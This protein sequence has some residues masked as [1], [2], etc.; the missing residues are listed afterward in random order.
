L[1]LEMADSLNVAAWVSF[2]GI[3]AV[4]YP[5]TTAC[6]LFE[7]SLGRKFDLNKKVLS[8]TEFA[9]AASSGVF[10][11]FL[12]RKPL[13]RAEKKLLL[14]NYGKKRFKD[15]FVSNPH[16]DIPSLNKELRGDNLSDKGAENMYYI[17]N[18]K[19]NLFLSKSLS[20]INIGSL[21]KNKKLMSQL[22]CIRD[23]IESAQIVSLWLTPPGETTSPCTPSTLK[24]KYHLAFPNSLVDSLA[25]GIRSRKYPAFLSQKPG[26]RRE[27]VAFQMALRDGIKDLEERTL[28]SLGKFPESTFNLDNYC[29]GNNACVSELNEVSDTSPSQPAD[30]DVDED[31]LSDVPS[32]SDGSEP[33]SFQHHASSVMESS[34]LIRSIVEASVAFGKVMSEA[35]GLV[36]QKKLDLEI[37]QRQLLD[38]D[39]VAEFYS[40]NASDGYRMNRTRKDYLQQRHIIKNEILV[41]EMM[42]NYFCNGITASGISSFVNSIMNLDRRCYTT[43]ALTV[44]EVKNLIRNPK[45]QA[46]ILG[47]TYEPSA[48]G[49]SSVSQAGD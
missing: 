35:Q 40:L 34:S 48:E 11:D 29:E 49:E 14:G 9:E 37:V 17:V 21:K 45:T 16:S 39:H 47:E 28:L 7:K 31:L 6:S 23:D 25:E 30:M 3:S 38:L 13:N 8:H 22:F 20:W 36:A 42:G 10:P 1:G 12:L 46:Q 44:A 27:I 2:D 41:L 24:R 32:L 18:T 43:R 15:N 5:E 4:P 19:C 33:F 26:S